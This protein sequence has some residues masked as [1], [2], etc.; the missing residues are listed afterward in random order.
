MMLDEDGSDD[1]NLLRQ[2]ETQ[3]YTLKF[4]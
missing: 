4:T 2:D 1:E 3:R